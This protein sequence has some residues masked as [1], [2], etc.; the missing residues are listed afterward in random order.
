MR[1]PYHYIIVFL[2]FV[3]A[4]FLVVYGISTFITTLLFYGVLFTLLKNL[5]TLIKNKSKRIIILKNTKSVLIIMLVFEFLLTFVF[6]LLNNTMENEKFLYFSEYKKKEQS[7]LLQKLGFHTA[8]FTY[9]D[10]YIPNSSRIVKR[11]EFSFTHHY[12]ELGLRGKL[13]KTEKDSNE[14]R[15]LVLGDSFIEGDGADDRNTLPVHLE[16]LLSSKTPGKKITVVNGGISGSNPIYEIEVYRKHLSVYKPDLVILA[17]YR[18]DIA[19]IDVML[20]NGNIPLKEY[21]SAVSHLFRMIYFGILNFDNFELNH[22]PKKTSERRIQLYHFLS[23]KIT[24]FSNELNKNGIHFLSL[25]IA[26]KGEITDDTFGNSYSEALIKTI[27]TDINLKHEFH[28]LNIRSTD[29]LT[30]YFWN[31]DAHFKKEGYK[32]AA[33]IIAKKITEDYD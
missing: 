3:H 33:K 1:R 29:S 24:S 17:L 11:P 18:N 5:F 27:D 32:L 13:P 9:T 20:H 21:F 16:S 15:I 8:R 28:Q 2:V 22:I 7:Q 4:Y 23:E 19:E 26:S 31:S 6:K 14:F 30:N 10:L 12:N 25:Y